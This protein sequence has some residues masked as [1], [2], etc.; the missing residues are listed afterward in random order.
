MTTQV[1]RTFD[2]RLL[3]SSCHEMS[4]VMSTGAEAPVM[5]RRNNIYYV[6]CGPVY[7]DVSSSA[8]SEGVYLFLAFGTFFNETRI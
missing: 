5:F 2:P 7:A 1:H 8:K 3:D 4:K 6:L